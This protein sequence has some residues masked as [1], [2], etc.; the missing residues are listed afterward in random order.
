MIPDLIDIWYNLAKK[1]ADNSSKINLDNIDKKLSMSQFIW[2]LE[3]KLYKAVT[4]YLKNKI[5]I[6]SIKN[7][8]DIFIWS[9]LI[10]FEYL[11]CLNSNKIKTND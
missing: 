5:R 7:K 1:K 8:I 9:F 2:K 10:Y 4:K 6:V 3:Y 11:L